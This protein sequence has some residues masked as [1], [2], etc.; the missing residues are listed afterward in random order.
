MKVLLV[1]NIT[2]LVTSVIIPEIAHL[3]LYTDGGVYGDS[4]THITDV[5]DDTDDSYLLSQ[6]H[7]DGEA[8][9]EHPV[10]PSD[11]HHWETTTLSWVE[12]LESAKEATLREVETQANLEVM[13]S[14]PSNTQWELILKE[15]D[16]PSAAPAF[17]DMCTFLEDMK[18]KTKKTKD[19]IEKS[20]TVADMIEHKEKH[21][22][23]HPSPK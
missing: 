17:K 22:S 3:S 9:V 2:K 1:N 10:Q 16:K 21:K 19:K 4:T 8:F 15:L 14:Y 23:D 7:C 5:Y 12:D 13:Q 11:Y 20:K 18:T 6:L